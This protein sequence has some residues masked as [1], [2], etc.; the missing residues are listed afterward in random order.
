[1]LEP[2]GDE[3]S[4]LHPDPISQLEMRVKF[5]HVPITSATGAPV[6]STLH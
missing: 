5:L 3:A 4:N 1:V 6:G 2:E